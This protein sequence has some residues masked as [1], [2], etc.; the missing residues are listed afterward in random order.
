M[1]YSLNQWFFWGWISSE[2]Q[3]LVS[4]Q[5]DGCGITTCHHFFSHS[6]FLVLNKMKIHL[7]RSLWSIWILNCDETCSIE[8][9]VTYLLNGCR[10][11]Y[12][13]TGTK[14]G[15]FKIGGD[16]V[17]QIPNE[18]SAYMIGALLMLFWNWCRFFQNKLK[19][20][21][22]STISHSV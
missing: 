21:Y 16:L 7:L 8:M 13:L 2:I 1:Y 4:P 6:E 3:Y 19:F 12:L 10:S 5:L 17:D 11:T 22:E 18:I 14:L 20:L 15:F 9:S